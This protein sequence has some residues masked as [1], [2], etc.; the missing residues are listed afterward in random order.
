MHTTSRFRL[1]SFLLAGSLLMAGAVTQAMADDMP[2]DK[3]RVRGVVESLSGDQLNINTREGNKVAIELQEGWMVSAVAKASISDIKK[4]DFVGIASLPKSDGGDGALEVLIFPA[5]L[6]GMGEGSYSWDLKPGSSMTNATVANTVKSVDNS[7]V[8][9]SYH[10]KE[11]KI[12][13]PEGT[14]VVTLA[15]ATPEDVKPG[16]AI[17]VSADKGMDDKLSANSLLVGKDGVVPP[18]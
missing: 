11:K 10:G 4:G 7:E 14:P 12:A 5:E 16:S 15:P 1:L 8:T 2:S 13:I 9:V 6:K 18:M 17:F 3:V